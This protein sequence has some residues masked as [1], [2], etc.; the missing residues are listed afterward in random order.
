MPT[1]EVFD[2]EVIAE[3]GRKTTTWFVRYNDGWVRAAEHPNATVQKLDAGPGTVWERRIEI[4][5]PKGTLVARVDSSPAAEAPRDALAHLTRGR[6]S[7]R[8]TTR[9]TE[10]SVGPRGELI[11]AGRRPG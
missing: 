4:V 6:R 11:R 8:R 1:I 3:R 10:L 9:R 5:L 2:A 7:Q